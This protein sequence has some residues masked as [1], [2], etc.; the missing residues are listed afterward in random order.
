[1]RTAVSLALIAVI[2]TGCLSPTITGPS[3]IQQPPRSGWTTSQVEAH[4]G[5]PY[6]T[7]WYQT[8]G[9]SYESWLYQRSYLVST[10]YGH[11]VEAEYASVQ[12]VDGVVVGVSY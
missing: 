1:M 7:S 10:M 2:L 12:F 4:W 3:N 8:G 9:R 5:I 6:S 11:T